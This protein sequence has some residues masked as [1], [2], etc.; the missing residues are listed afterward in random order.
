M[1]TDINF[2]KSLGISK[3]CNITLASNTV[4]PLLLDSYPNAAVAYSLR[5]LRNAYLGSAIRVRRAIDNAEQD[6]GFDSLGNLDTEALLDF[7]GYNL[8]IWSEDLSQT[9]WNKS[10]LQVSPILI[11][12]PLGVA[13]GRVLLE[14]AVTSTHAVS[15]ATSGVGGNT[16][17]VSFW[18]KAQGRDN[19]RLT[20]TT[21][22]NSRQ[23][24]LNLAT[25]T[26]VS[27]PT[28]FVN[29]T[30][31]P[32]INDWYLVSFTETAANAT[33]QITINF[34]PDGS[35]ITYL[36]D[37]TKGMAIWGLQISETSTIKPYQKTEINA[38][39]NGFITTW[40][41][42]S[43]N[44]N[45]AIQATPS[46]QAQIVS[47]GSFIMIGS[48]ITTNWTT[49]SY[50]ISSFLTNKPL[51][52]TFVARRNGTGTSG[53]MTSFANSG[54]TI[55]AVFRW[56][57]VNNNM[58]TFLNTLRTHSSNN[59]FTGYY[60][61]TT[62]KTVADFVNIRNNSVELTGGIATGNGAINS[63][64]NSNGSGTIGNVNEAILWYQDYESLIPEIETKINEYY[65]IY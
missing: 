15:R 6:F 24:W 44:G 54:T 64:G 50:T 21:G 43:T 52:S 62:Y 18:I 10:S 36:G 25:G 20:T 29:L 4:T 49:D 61:L 65:A 12:D 17:T 58:V 26:I 23:A 32:D 51:V 46:S 28:P 5:K 41:D 45:N 39:G 55:A 14:T 47:N 11:N 48:K 40:Y 59:T 60:L 30:I 2:N 33:L 22:L 16:Y 38:G 3:G 19:F 63:F 57:S 1:A 9:T 27:Q 53:Q 31:T 37:I 8:A 35:N 56:I 7:N 42:Q 34:S 13:S